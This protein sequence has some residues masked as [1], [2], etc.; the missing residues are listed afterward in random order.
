MGLIYTI[1][2]LGIASIIREST[3]KATYLNGLVQIRNAT[4][5]VSGS[6]TN[7]NDSA[8]RRL[9]PKVYEGHFVKPGQ[10]IM[11]QRG[12]KV[13]PGE[14]TDIGKDHTIYAVEPGYVRF[15]Y[16]PFHPLRKFV[17]VALKKSL[18]LPTPH[19]EPRVRRF[20]YE[21]ISDP[22]KAEQEENRM[23]RK[24]LLQQEELK[25]IESAKREFLVAKASSYKEGLKL[26]F[27]LDFKEDELEIAA[28]RLLNISQLLD[29]GLS[30]EEARVQATYNYIHSL[31][32]SF[33]RGELAAGDLEASKTSYLN[34]INR[35]DA[36]VMID[37]RGLLCRHVDSIYRDQKQKEIIDELRTLTYNKILYGED[38]KNALELIETPGIFLKH[39]Q[40]NLKD[41]YLPKIAPS[42][43]SVIE[44]NAAVS[45]PGD[46]VISRV[47][48]EAKKSVRSVRR[49]KELFDIN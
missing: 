45:N 47:F 33:K 11:R 4:K 42:V 18:S 39:E 29:V 15:Y 25:S 46:L 1:G 21:V 8:G 37:G 17:G 36:D 16:N 19:F 34:F 20:G 7:K 6:K 3:F 2:R 27:K 22:S 12:T 24:E 10:I 9:G 5:K 14:N 38:R 43:A 26:K 32:L 31:S 30:F 48:D 35:L 23:S 28:S 13:H 40:E 44:E 41:H 49:S